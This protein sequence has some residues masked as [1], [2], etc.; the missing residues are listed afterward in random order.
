[1]VLATGRDYVDVA[2]VGGILLGA[3]DQDIEV[4][5]DLVPLDE[6]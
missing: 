1:M 5:V 4:N 2:P 3:G 6:V